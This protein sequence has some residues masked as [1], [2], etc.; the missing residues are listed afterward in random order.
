MRRLLLLIA[1]LLPV[2]LLSFALV[3]TG[4]LA[5]NRYDG[6]SGSLIHEGATNV[7][8]GVPQ[9]SPSG[10]QV[11]AAY[12]NESGKSCKTV[13]F[14]GVGNLSAIPEFDGITSP[15]W[16]GIIDSDA[17]GT[18]NIAHEPSPETIAFWLEGDP[19]SRSIEFAEAVSEVTFFYASYVAV[20]LE[21]FDKDGKSLG[22][23]T[24]PANWN[25]GPGGDP[26][27]TYNKWDSIS[28]KTSGNSI[29]SIK[30]I[31]NENNT[32]I[33]DLT[34]C[35]KI[36][37]N[38][39]EFTQVIQEL[40][41]LEDFKTDISSDKTPP[42]PIVA[43]KPL[44]LRV[45]MEKVDTSTEV[46]LKLTGVST[47][48][49]KATLQ[50]NCLPEA[51]RSGEGGCRS[52]DF[53]FTPP[54]GDWSATLKT[55]DKSGSEVESHTFVLT[56][57]ET[58][59]LIL[60][61][62][63]VCDSRKYAVAGEWRCADD[64]DLGGLIGLLEQTAPTEDVRVEY[65]GDTV[66]RNSF[67]Y[68]NKSNWWVD[69][70]RDIHDLGIE[71]Y[72]YGMIRPD[73]TGS[74]GGIAHNIPSHGA[75]SRTSVVRLGTETNS[76]VVA[77]ETGH[78]LGRRHTNTGV[79][80]AAAPPGC[81][82]TAQDPGTDWPYGNNRIQSGPSTNP[83]LEVGFDVGNR[84]PINPQNTYDWMSYCTPRWISPHTY[85]NA[86][87]TLRA[88][89][90]TNREDLSLVES[91]FWRVSGVID[92]TTTLDPLFEYVTEASVAAGSG[93]HQIEV[94]DASSL[95]FTRNF[96]PSELHTESGNPEEDIEAL[97]FSELI[98]A[99]SNAT[100]I[101]IK[102]DEGRELATIELSGSAP[103]VTITS[104]S[105]NQTLGGNFDLRWQITDVDSK[106][107]TSWVQYS[108]D[109]GKSWK[110]FASALVDTSLEVDFGKIAGSNGDALVRVL[111]S[112]GAKTGSDTSAAF[113][114]PKK[115][116]AVE[117][118]S[119]LDSTAFKLGDLIDL[120]A[121]AYD[122]ED[123][124]S[125][126]L[127]WSSDKDG[128]IGS[129]THAPTTD[130]SSGEHVVT[131]LATDSD[132]MTDS[133]SITIFVDSESP[134]L[135]LTIA[136]DSTP[137]SCVDVTINALD[138]V[139]GTGLDSVMYSFDG[140]ISWSPVDLQ[141]LPLSFRVPGKGF[142]HLI[143]KATDKAGNFAVADERYFIETACPNV[144]P[145]A[146][147]GDGYIGN[148]GTPILIDG[149]KSSD[150]DGSII[151]YEWD[152]DADGK[153]DD[154]IGVNPEATFPDNGSFDI[155]LRVTDFVGAVATDETTVVV[156]NVSPEVDAGR[157]WLIIEGE[158]IDLDEASFSDAGPHDTHSAAVDW[159]DGTEKEN[160]YAGEGIITGAHVYN[161]KGN[162]TVEVCVTDNDAAMTCDTLT[163][164][165]EPQEFHLF[166]PVLRRQ[167]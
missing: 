119:P 137:A 10:K 107:F 104:P 152:F 50:P 69:I 82:S 53:Y 165:V 9:N 31:G 115:S 97:V 131:I 63:S 125:V 46:T 96:T 108:N 164:V 142:F 94:R 37:I 30:V 27:G 1:L 32:G 60:K 5:A 68:I 128:F 159:G 135:E 48:E 47:M 11:A 140:G 35:R 83:R 166:L 109:N 114:V 151:L 20:Q 58:A 133:D 161:E 110:T 88:T 45:Y 22:T 29:R 70:A 130:L 14:E 44:A 54:A 141:N 26:E 111:V 80:A 100:Q 143:A 116:V 95:L 25:T 156:R 160:L 139:G 127:T 2:L 148:E 72:Y 65:P 98:P 103:N 75:A 167:P 134:E 155:E 8:R 41:T 17:G 23:A 21:A 55:F 77:H 147:A 28:L 86:L 15:G 136:L 102:D 73:A 38:S 71:P 120:R 67:Y 16:L 101:A 150:P 132:G 34:V 89:S 91:V 123:G 153:F 162:Y 3:S 138:P 144:P 52:I 7:I 78:M 154:A 87:N 40:Q 18:G 12:S 33:D 74:F 62:V 4:T 117:I 13:N 43:D 81:Y 19:S 129:G 36:G 42:V 121:D 112:D 113:T 85:R 79:P 158:G 146:D 93:T 59:P 105:G 61:A 126:A 6:E 163:V 99:Y 66:R 118:R 124:A 84:R 49:Q 90:N 64:V 122:P 56:S 76:E 24:G 92:D 157:D 106:E 57:V 51:A 39:V 149:S 145:T